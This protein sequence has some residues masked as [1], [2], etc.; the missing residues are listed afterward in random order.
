M[1]VLK[2]LEQTTKKPKFFAIEPSFYVL[3]MKYLPLF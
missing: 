1:E 2:Y 3:Q